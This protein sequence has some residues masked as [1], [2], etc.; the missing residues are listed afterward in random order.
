MIVS[1]RAASSVV[2]RLALLVSEASGERVLAD[3][4]VTEI[5]HCGERDWLF[6]L[7]G[8]MDRMMGW[9][10]GRLLGRME[11]LLFLTSLPV[12]LCWFT[13]ALTPRS[14]FGRDRSTRLGAVAERSSFRSVGEIRAGGKVDWS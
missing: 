6:G 12:L 11:R 13:M 14:A 9:M 2:G 5:V 7:G 1:R 3:L 4:G 10:L 8:M